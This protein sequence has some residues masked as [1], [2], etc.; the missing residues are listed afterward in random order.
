MLKYNYG[1]LYI[2]RLR[3]TDRLIFT[4][5]KER[6]E[7]NKILETCNRTGKTPYVL[8]RR[9]FPGEIGDIAESKKKIISNLT[10]S[11]GRYP[12]KEIFKYFCLPYQI[13]KRGMDA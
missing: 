5:N 2:R 7:L 8:A 12:L 6:S 11:D 1:E 13:Y 10:N 9:G 4:S 3:K